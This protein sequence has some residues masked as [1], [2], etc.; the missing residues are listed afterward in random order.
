MVKDETRSVLRYFEHVLGTHI[1]IWVKKDG[2]EFSVSKDKIKKMC[3]EGKHSQA[4]DKIVNF[5]LRW[6]N[7]LIDK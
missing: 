3:D 5:Y 1:Q 4:V 6:K 2:Q 7:S